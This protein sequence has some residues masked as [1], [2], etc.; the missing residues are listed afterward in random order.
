MVMMMIY[1]GANLCLQ[2]SGRRRR[3]AMRQTTR[4]RV[5]GNSGAESR[6]MNGEGARGRKGSREGAFV[7]VIF[8]VC[9]GQGSEQQKLGKKW[10]SR[11]ASEKRNERDYRFYEEKRKRKHAQHVITHHA[12]VV[13]LFPYHD[14]H[15][16]H[17]IIF[18]SIHPY[19]KP[20]NTGAHGGAHGADPG[21]LRRVSSIFV[22]RY[23]SLSLSINFVC[24]IDGINTHMQVKG[25]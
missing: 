12:F 11:R 6:G 2:S 15:T 16:T 21:Y 23:V 9:A 4:A 13:A 25:F 14:S 22:F 24:V 3:G 19:Y 20:T 8:T 1:I 10:S 5:E 7:F 17:R 18:L